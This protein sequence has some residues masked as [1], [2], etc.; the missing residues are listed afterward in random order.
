[1]EILNQILYWI[2][3]GLMI[4]VMLILCFFFIRAL[5]AIGGFYGLYQK[6][7]KSRKFLDEYLLQIERKGIERSELEDDTM[8]SS[9]VE[10]LINSRSA[11][12]RDK[13]LD[14]YEIEMSRKLTSSKRMSKLGPVLGLLGTLIPMGPALV[15]L[16]SGDIG[17][18]AQNM[19]VAFSTTVVGLVVGAIGFLLTEIKQGWFAKELSNLTY[20]ADLIT[21][22][23]EKKK[24]QI[25]N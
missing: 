4:P 1:M 10:K 9:F 21:E 12:F 15:G 6:Q 22:E 11:V 18:M 2:S 23:N 3:T 14:D 19:Q 24:E 8:I 16:A 7:L 20:I 25:L 5:L 17:S 13:V